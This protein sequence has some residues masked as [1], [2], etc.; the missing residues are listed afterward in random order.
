MLSGVSIVCFAASYAVA[1][2]LEVSRLFFRSGVRGAIMLAFAA[3]GLLAHTAFLAHRAAE[4]AGSPLSSKQEWY[5][6]TAWL[7]VVVYLYLTYFHPKQAFGVFI[8]PLVLGL[9]GVGTLAADA[10]PFAREPASRIWG[11]IHGSSILLATAAMLVGFAAGLMYLGQAYRL[12]RKLPPLRGFQLP[13][14]EWLQRANSRAIVISLLLLAVGI[15]AGVVLNLINR[16]RQ[17]TLLPWSDPL[18]L[19]TLGMFGWLVVSAGV[20]VFYRPTREG[21]KVAYLTVVSFVFL[22]IAL[23]IGMSVMTQHSGKQEGTQ[24]ERVE[25]GVQGSGFRVQ[26]SQL[27]PRPSPLAL[28]QG[29]GA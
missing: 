3:A 8:L 20:G 27:A 28:L 4:A 11:G 24:G 6:L 1:L 18:V 23:G 14:L 9:I 5:L 10:E 7:L 12:K 22:V 17:V 29:G 21:Q 19:S 26:D 15:L 25:L 13:S 2:G 16:Q